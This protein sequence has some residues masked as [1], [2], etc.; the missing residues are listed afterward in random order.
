MPVITSQE[1]DFRVHVNI[2]MCR[3]AVL[4]DDTPGTKIQETIACWQG[5]NFS[6][7]HTSRS[8]KGRRDFYRHLVSS[9]VN[10]NATKISTKGCL[11]DSLGRYRPLGAQND[12]EIAEEVDQEDEERRIHP[13]TSEDESDNESGAEGLYTTK[14]IEKNY[15]EGSRFGFYSLEN[16]YTH[17]DDSYEH[18]ETYADPRHLI[19]SSS[20]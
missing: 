12:G 3:E 5:R 20:P 17:L 1:M 10:F 18:S 4:R 8:C 13:A 16:G 14:G 11:V 7:A 9:S 2:W 6:S 19:T 15:L